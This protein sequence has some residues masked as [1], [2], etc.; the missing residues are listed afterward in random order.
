MRGPPDRS[1]STRHQRSQSS[2][3]RS[4]RS[5]QTATNSLRRRSG[6]G[7]TGGLAAAVPCRACSRE[8]AASKAV[9]PQR[10]FFAYVLGSASV[11]FTVA[12][13][14]E[15][16]AFSQATLEA[17]QAGV[18]NNHSHDTNDGNSDSKLVARPR[19]SGQ[20]GAFLKCA[21]VK[22]QKYARFRH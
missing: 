6:T 21:P 5:Y 16:P 1:C 14:G 3:L 17:E 11:E 7:R 22:R 4:F 15:E 20:G 13:I 12:Q 8:T 18:K 10:L 2:V 9:S 19:H